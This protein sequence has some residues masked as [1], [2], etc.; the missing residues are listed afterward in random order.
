MSLKQDVIF[1]FGGLVVIAVSVL[2]IGKTLR[3]PLPSCTTEILEVTNNINFGR[4]MLLAPPNVLEAVKSSLPNDVLR[5]N[6]S[7]ILAAGINALEN[8]KNSVY[9]KTLLSVE[10]KSPA[11]KETRET[12]HKKNNNCQM[13]DKEYEVYTGSA[14]M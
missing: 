11:A 12:L 2:A 4:T 3:K 7:L 1:G 14:L 13:L 9:I 6:S 5:D 10:D 8:G